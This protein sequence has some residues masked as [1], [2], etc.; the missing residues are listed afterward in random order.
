MSVDLIKRLRDVRTATFATPTLCAEAADLIESQAR[1]IGELERVA[2]DVRNVAIELV[3]RLDSD[4][5]ARGL[6]L[7][8]ALAGLL[9]GYTPETDR[10]H[11]AIVAL[12]AERASP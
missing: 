4:E 5:D 9:P 2:R 12:S 10:V 8:M 1:R 7:A 11:A 3:R 6:K